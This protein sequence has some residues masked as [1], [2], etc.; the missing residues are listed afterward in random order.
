VSREEFVAVGN[1][2][3]KFGERAPPI[4]D[5][6]NRDDQI[7]GELSNSKRENFAR[8]VEE[9]KDPAKAFVMAGFNVHRSN[10]A[11]LMRQP[12]IAARIA[13]LRHER[14]RATAARAA[15]IP[16]AEVLSELRQHGIDR[17][18]DFFESGL[19]GLVRRD[20][21]AIRTEVSV[22]LMTSLCKA[23]GLKDV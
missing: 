20:L 12:A 11:R 4:P 3:G 19:G 18:A 8:A 9:G 7:M 5:P 2:A 22:A 23:F 17:V 15:Q 14:E 10:H 13:E 16:A 1:E 21:R 6:I